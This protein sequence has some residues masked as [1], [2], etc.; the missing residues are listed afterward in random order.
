[1]VEF[2]LKLED[3]KVADW[4]DEYIDYE[5][6][7]A[8]L[9]KIKS[10]MKKKEELMQRKPDLAREIQFAYEQQQQEQQQ[11]AEAAA[12]SSPDD[13]SGGPSTP[14]VASNQRF[15]FD[16]ILPMIQSSQ[17]DAAGRD[18]V[19]NTFLRLRNKIRNQKD[20]VTTSSIVLRTGTPFAIR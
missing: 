3:N 7:K 16:S 14:L 10:A 18:Q 5:K 17:K 12:A 15:S 19:D 1:M 20:N 11:L 8:T 4:A 13:T 2:G 6:L 9:A